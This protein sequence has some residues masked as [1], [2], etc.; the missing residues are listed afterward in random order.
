MLNAPLN[1]PVLSLS[2]VVECRNI[3]MIVY[4]LYRTIT[5]KHSQNLYVWKNFFIHHKVY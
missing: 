1:Q 4:A 5:K 3:E 2:A